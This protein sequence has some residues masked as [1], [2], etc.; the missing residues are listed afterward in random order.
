MSED[1][2]D[3]IDADMHLW[4]VHLTTPSYQNHGTIKASAVKVVEATNRD[5]AIQQARKLSALDEKAVA[6]TIYDLGPASPSTHERHL[7]D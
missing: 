5:A 2:A 7:T 3:S 1:G 4:E 6:Q